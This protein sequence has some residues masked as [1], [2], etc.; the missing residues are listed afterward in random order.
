MSLLILLLISVLLTE[1]CIGEPIKQSFAHSIDLNDNGLYHSPI[2]H[3]INLF[4]SLNRSL[5]TPIFHRDL[6][7][8]GYP[9]TIQTL[10]ESYSQSRPRVRNMCSMYG[11][12]MPYDPSGAPV[13]PPID[14]PNY[15]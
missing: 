13:F 3:A 8:Y 11:A 5:D 10:D 1:Q 9:S 14:C 12:C 7:V 2:S 4:Q 15:T 6:S